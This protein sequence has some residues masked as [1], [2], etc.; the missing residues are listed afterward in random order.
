MDENK[1]QFINQ[2]L[3]GQEPEIPRYLYKYRP[4]DRYTYDML[5]NAYLYLCPAKNL[6]DPSECTV[7]FDTQD[8][9]DFESNRLIFRCVE[10]ILE[11]I[12][13]HT[14]EDNFNNLRSVIARTITP[15]GYVRR[16]FLLDALFEM[17]KYA[18][19]EDCIALVNWLGNIPERLD[20]PTI[21]SQMEKLFLAAYKARDD[22]GICSLSVL[23]NDDEMWENYT[24]GSAGYCVE[25]DM[26][27]YEHSEVVFPVIYDDERANNIAMTIMAD[28]IAQAIYGVSGGQLTVD[29]SNYIRM[30]LTK[31]SKWDYQK[32]WRIIGDANERIAAPTIKAIYLGKNISDE[33]RKAMQQYSAEHDIACIQR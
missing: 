6:D 19:K 23:D 25:F 16:D 26:T 8:Y 5:D 27:G 22:M 31:E 15:N 28:F 1:I 11:I 32:E 21:R 33:N 24:D 18:P 3:T 4:F 30:F 7:S 13:P 29:R 12:R 17:E 9:F 20:S 14:S 2:K 10:L